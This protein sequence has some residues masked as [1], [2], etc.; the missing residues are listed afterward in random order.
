MGAFQ[1]LP[2]EIKVIILGLSAEKA[3]QPFE[4]MKFVA[5]RDASYG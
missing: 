1:V 2:W 4:G 3:Y 5:F